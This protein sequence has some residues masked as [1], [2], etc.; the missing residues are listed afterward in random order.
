MNER[1]DVQ[2]LLEQ[3][4]QWLS[5]THAEAEA[6]AAEPDGAAEPGGAD[7][8][9]VGL[10]E[11]VREFTVLRHEV[12]LQT[13]SARGLEETAA[14]AVAALEEAVR[15][16]RGVEPQ[17]AEAARRAATPLVRGP[18]RIGRGA[19]PRAGRGRGRPAAA[20]RGIGRA[21][22]GGLRRLARLET[23]AAARLARRVHRDSAAGR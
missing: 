9:T 16:F 7:G 4:R 15:Q 20:R 11:I 1:P 10:M 22:G 23:L 19:A 14:A 8:Q 21:A 6:A 2:P 5:Q 13:K 18:G 3:F 12:K 17:E